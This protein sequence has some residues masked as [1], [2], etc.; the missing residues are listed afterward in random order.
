[1]KDIKLSQNYS[2][3]SYITAAFVLLASL[4][5]LFL[6][7]YDQENANWA[8]QAMGQ[9]IG[10]IIAVAVLV[11]ALSQY[12]KWPLMSFML[13]AGSMFYVAYAYLIY[14]FA[15]HFNYLFLLYVAILGLSISLLIGGFFANT[16]A[17]K[18]LHAKQKTAQNLV[19]GVLIFIGVVFMLLWLKEVIPSLISGQLPDS[20][21]QAGLVVNP[22]HVIDFAIALPS[23]IL[24]GLSLRRKGM[25]G[26]LIAGPWLVFAVLMGLSI[27]AAMIV[28]AVKGFAG[29]LQPVTPIAVIV[30]ISLASYVKYYRA[31]SNASAR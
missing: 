13:W 2:A 19:G 14:A 12:K 5:G 21:V 6:G 7:A 31:T 16:E 17:L 30:A 22:V 20:A 3:L 15:L 9:D 24:A 4:A 25:L 29:A 18:K 26:D 28:M 27:I 1:M 10:N 8:A 23:A 11:F